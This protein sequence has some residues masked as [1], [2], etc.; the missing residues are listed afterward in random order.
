MTLL[1]IQIHSETNIFLSTKVIWE[2]EKRGFISYSSAWGS[3]RRVCLKILPSR[4]NKIYIYEKWQRNLGC[5]RRFTKALPWPVGRDGKYWPGKEPIR[6]QDSLPCPLK[7]KYMLF[8]GRSVRMV[9]NCD[10]GLENTARGRASLQIKGLLLPSAQTLVW[11]SL[12]FLTSLALTWAI[13]LTTI[14][15]HGL[16]FFLLRY[17]Y[18][19]Y[20]L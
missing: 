3:D 19:H 5:T 13:Y 11:P 4:E 17:S 18:Y 12:S 7:K 6:L 15:S 9:K 1:L 2:R 16:P 8:T 10:R 20:L 14:V